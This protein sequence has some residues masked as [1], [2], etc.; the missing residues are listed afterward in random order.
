MVTRGQ[1]SA[2]A[3]G[4]LGPLGRAQVCPLIKTALPT[5][6]MDAQIGSVV[7]GSHHLLRMLRRLIPFIPEEDTAVV[8]GTIINSR[9][10]YANSLY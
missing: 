5:M 9:L 8:V 2:G 7:S 6:T 10:D 3:P 4:Q 1:E